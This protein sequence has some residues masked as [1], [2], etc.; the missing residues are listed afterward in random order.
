M[1]W[2]AILSLIASSL[3][4]AKSC[5]RDKDCLEDIICSMVFESITLS[6]M[7]EEGEQVQL[8][9]ATV[10]SSKFDKT[11]NSLEESPMGGPCTIVK[12]RHMKWLSP[13]KP[14]A[15]EFKGWVGDN[16]V[17]EQVFQVRHDCCHVLLVEGPGE[18][19]LD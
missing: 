1:K 6:V 2:L 13:S 15:V 5:N 14:Q 4:A 3:G 11:I 9:K 7:D 16:L 18:I 19:T 12:D 10:T 8:T 17:V